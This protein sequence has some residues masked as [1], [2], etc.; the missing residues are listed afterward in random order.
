VLGAGVKLGAGLAERIGGIADVEELDASVGVARGE[1]V[2]ADASIEPAADLVC[3]GVWSHERLRL[4][5]VGRGS[6]SRG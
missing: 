6:G 1:V 5:R 4:A 3:A 2:R